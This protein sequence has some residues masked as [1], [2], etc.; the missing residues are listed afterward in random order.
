MIDIAAKGYLKLSEAEA[1]QNYFAK[2]QSNPSI[3]PS[4]SIY[5]IAARKINIITS[6]KRPTC[7]FCGNICGFYWYKKKP[8]VNSNFIKEDNLLKPLGENESLH[9]ALKSLTAT[10]LVCSECFS[11]GNYPKILR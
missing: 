1:L 2:D 7:N 11:L 8:A 3:N 10:Y 9:Q 6:Y 5:L 4:E